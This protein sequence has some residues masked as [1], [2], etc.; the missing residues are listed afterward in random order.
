[1]Y[2]RRHNSGAFTRFNC[3]EG[4]RSHREECIGIKCVL[5][6]FETLF[7][8]I[9]IQRVTPE[10]RKNAHVRIRLKCSLLSLGFNH[11]WNE[12]TEF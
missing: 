6:L 2:A 5:V 8:P 1:M 10:M 11:N 7:V 4:R 12:F 3:F 9:D